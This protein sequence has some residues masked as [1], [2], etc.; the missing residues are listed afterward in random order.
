M[1]KLVML[2]VSDKRRF[3]LQPYSQAFLPLSLFGS[4]L[5]GLAVNKQTEGPFN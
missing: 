3:P 2:D 1:T 4:I 5:F